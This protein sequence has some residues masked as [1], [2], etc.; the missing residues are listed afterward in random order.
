MSRTLSENLTEILD[1]VVKMVNFIKTKS[2]KLQVFKK[3]CTNLDSQHKKLLL[4]TD[5]RWLSR[6]K[7]L[8]RVHELQHKLFAFFEA[9]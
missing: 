5:V 4:H 1:E 7:V 2:A 3:I 8:V 9:I 6:G